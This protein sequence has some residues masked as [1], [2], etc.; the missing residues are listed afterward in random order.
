LLLNKL[1]EHWR[2]AARTTDEKSGLTLQEWVEAHRGSR[3]GARL[4]D[5]TPSIRVCSHE[6]NKDFLTLWKD[7]DPGIPTLEESKV[8]YAK[9]Q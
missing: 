8:G 7:A 6:T 9:L 2:E 4:G 3:P 1:R 5:R